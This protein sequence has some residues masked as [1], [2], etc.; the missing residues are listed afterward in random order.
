MNHM[1]QGIETFLCITA[2]SLS[3][4]GEASK[5]KAPTE[6][7]KK[8]NTT[9]HVSNVG[10]EIQRGS[11]ELENDVL[12]IKRRS[13][14]RK[15]RY[16]HILVAYVT[17]AIAVITLGTIVG[18]AVHAGLDGRDC[19][20]GDSGRS[21]SKYE[22]SGELLGIG[23]S[24]FIGACTMLPTGIVGSVLKTRARR[25]LNELDHGGVTVRSPKKQARL[26]AGLSI[27]RL[28]LNIQF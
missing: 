5:V 10:I 11:P 26:T 21:C 9:E 1:I 14:K 25:E 13:A 3:V 15:Y 2:V 28:F 27:G 6:N 22:D 4:L 16:G 23:W 18:F 7:P 19:S 24:V 8:E 12:E 20:E 17:P